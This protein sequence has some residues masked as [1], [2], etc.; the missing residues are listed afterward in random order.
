MLKMKNIKKLLSFMLIIILFIFTFNISTSK[1]LNYGGVDPD[2][3]CNGDLN[4]DDVPPGGTVE[5][6]FQVLNL[7]EPG[8]LLDWEVVEWPKW[9]NWTFIPAKGNDLPS[10]TALTIVVIVVAP[11]DPCTT[12]NGEIIVEN[13]ENSDDFCIVDIVLTVEVDDNSLFYYLLENYPRIFPLFRQL[14]NMTY[15]LF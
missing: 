3:V 13:L 7:G 12:F 6:T 4:W 8:S 11:N 2:L 9:G 15:A 1:S 5:D 14:L 10:D